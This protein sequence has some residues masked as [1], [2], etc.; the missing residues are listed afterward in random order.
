[1]DIQE[2]VDF[3]AKRKSGG[4]NAKKCVAKAI[5]KIESNN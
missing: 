3:C 2:N 4:K 1:M 5:G